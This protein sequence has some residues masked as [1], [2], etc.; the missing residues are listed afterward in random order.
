MSKGKDKKGESAAA[1]KI[2]EEFERKLA[3]LG[4]LMDPMR[5]AES[6]PET[7]EPPPPEGPE[8]TGSKPPPDPLVP[9]PDNGSKGP[10]PPP[11][12]S[13]KAAENGSG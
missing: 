6:R 3:A 10:A 8:K 1:K 2:R 11:P 12:A 4:G 13:K 7:A 5:E 9:R